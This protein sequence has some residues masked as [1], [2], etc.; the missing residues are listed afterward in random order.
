MRL[1]RSQSAKAA[2]A[3]ARR[4]SSEANGEDYLTFMQ[5]AA[6]R[7]PEDP[8]FAI[9]NAL[10][11]RA[12]RP[13]DARAE[14]LRAV[15]LDRA[16]D[17]LLLSWAAEVLLG[18]GDVWAAHECAE[19]AM[20][21]GTTDPALIHSLAHIRGCIAAQR[22]ENDTAEDLLRQAHEG[23]P[24]DDEYG[25]NLARF[26]F[27]SERGISEALEIL[28]R[29]LAQPEKPEKAQEQ[30]R[31][32]LTELRKTI[33]EFQN[34]QRRIRRRKAVE[35]I[36]PPT[37]SSTTSTFRRPAVTTLTRRED[38]QSPGGPSRPS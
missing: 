21:A 23:E 22:K 15:R 35:S 33:V 12:S 18:S 26:L 16:G 31:P 3:E 25:L 34:L 7:F 8:R 28:D 10:A 4:L 32:K 2:L 38:D 1:R 20:R 24:A 27:S 14:A 36:G 13:E 17:P 37:T 30:I 5:E 29:A 6:P 19:R 9:L 11:L